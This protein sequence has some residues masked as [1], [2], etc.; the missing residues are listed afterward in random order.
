MFG[1]ELLFT[2]VQS[3]IRDSEDAL[4]TAAHW[5]LITNGFLC[6]GRGEQV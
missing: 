1:Y 5:T 6:V 3:Q 4:V 2:H